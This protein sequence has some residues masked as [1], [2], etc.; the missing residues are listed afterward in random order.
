MGND[1]IKDGSKVDLLAKG[2]I[3]CQVS[4]LVV[5]SIPRAYAEL[6]ISL[7]EA[8]TKVHVVCVVFMYLLW[9]WKPKDV[10]SPTLV[11]V[12]SCET[13]V[14]EMQVWNL[15]PVYLPHDPN[16]IPILIVSPWERLS[17]KCKLT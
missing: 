3:V 5:Q 7:L 12:A 17:K 4:W 6:S 10:G 9:W 2:L 16:N 14:A 1:S 15:D 11:D 8:H 13:V